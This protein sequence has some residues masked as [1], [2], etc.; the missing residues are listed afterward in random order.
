VR[1]AL[2]LG[3]RERIRPSLPEVDRRLKRID[4]AAMGSPN[5][6]PGLFDGLIVEASFPDA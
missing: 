6:Y 3:Y 5:A 1:A 2:P 4:R